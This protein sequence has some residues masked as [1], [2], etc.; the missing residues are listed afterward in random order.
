MTA[1]LAISGLPVMDDA[2]SIRGPAH[3][4]RAAARAL[5]ATAAAVHIDWCR[6]TGA[7]TGPEQQTVAVGDGCARGARSGVRGED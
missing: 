4:I 7:Y 1:G 5:H 3:G 2:E 6:M